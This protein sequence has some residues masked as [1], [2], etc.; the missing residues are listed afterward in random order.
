MEFG[1]MVSERGGSSALEHFMVNV[2]FKTDKH[3]REEK[4]TGELSCRRWRIRNYENND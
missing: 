2:D 3:Q 1:Q 4:A